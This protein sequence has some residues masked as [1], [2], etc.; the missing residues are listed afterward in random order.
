MNAEDAVEQFA[1]PAVIER[2]LRE[3]HVWAVV[4]CSSNPMR[5]SHGVSRTLLNHGYEIIPVN[6]REQQVHGRRSFP[7]LAS[8]AEWASAKGTPIEVVDIFRRADLAG[9]HVDEAIAIGA[10]AVWMQLRVIDAAAAQRARDAG[11]LVVMDR[12]PAI[13]LPRLGLRPS[14]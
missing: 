9:A 4:G 12:C 8:A 6:P 13:E 1:D 7:D 3:M 11:L 2:I 14:A 10:K 5:P